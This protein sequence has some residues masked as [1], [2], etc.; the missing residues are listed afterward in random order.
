MNYRLMLQVQEKVRPP[1]HEYI[2]KL[3][4][5]D[6]SKITIEKVLRQ[7]RKLPCEDLEVIIFNIHCSMLFITIL[8]KPYSFFP[9]NLF[10]RCFVPDLVMS[11]ISML[12]NI[13]TNCILSFYSTI[14]LNNENWIYFWIAPLSMND[15]WYPPSLV[16]TNFHSKTFHF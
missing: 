3:L 9:F 5:K 16:L 14:E 4:Y 11:I 7:M 12:H 1:M 10:S 6:L 13:L 15:F 8:L 2:R